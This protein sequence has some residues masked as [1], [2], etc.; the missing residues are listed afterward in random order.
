MAAEI[1]KL[2]G[3]PTTGGLDFQALEN[4]AKQCALRLAAAAVEKYLN[5]D[6]SDYSGP[7]L[8]CRCGGAA[9]FVER[10]S[11]TFQTVLGKVVLARAYYYCAA[12]QSGFCPRDRE[13]GLEHGSES[14][15]IQRMNALTAAMAGFRE[16]SFLLR[17]LAGVDINAM[18]A[19]I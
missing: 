3:R 17:E 9:T 6:L 1:Q 5:Q 13:L 12:C 11:K 16:S 10:R 4:A 14:P 19:I 15:G 2:I 7:Q 8:P 18:L